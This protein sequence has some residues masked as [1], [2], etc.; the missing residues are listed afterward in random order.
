MKD[1]AGNAAPSGGFKT[2]GWY[3][4]YQYWNGSFAPQAG[5]IHPESN[6]QGAGSAAPT[7]SQ[8]DADYIQSQNIKASQIQSPI[9]MSL[10]SSTASS[11]YVTGLND[12]VNQARSAIENYLSTQQTTIDTKLAT[13]KEKEQ[14][15]LGEMKTL[16]TPFRQDIENTERNRLFINENFNANQNLVDELDQLL[17]EGNNLIRQQQEVT[18]LAAVR[19][20]RIQK[21]MDDVTA[22][23]GVIQAV[24][25]ARNGQIS[26]AENM[27][28]RTINAIAADRQDQISYYE[29]ILNL[30]RQDI[31]SLSEESQKIAEE[32]LNLKKGDLQRA[33]ATADYVKQLLIDP[34]TASLMA[35]GGVKLTDSIEQINQKVASAVYAREVKDMSNEMVM[36]GGMAVLDPNSVPKNELRVLTDSKG[37]KHYYQVK[38]KTGGIGGGTASERATA[39][40][41]GVISNQA[42]NFPDVVVNYANQLSLSEIY[43]AY[44]QSEMGQKWGGPSE[45]P[46]EIALLY[47]WAR[48][49]IT[50]AEYRAALEG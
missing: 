13:L 29:T 45:N 47:K 32:Q 9:S 1:P 16:T 21:A 3:S 27:I 34:A 23:A 25:N 30:N 5:M 31:I 48:G 20:P 37:V 33:Q 7:F 50:E 36:S 41:S 39:R 14:A 38:D 19:N 10:P 17:T 18:G 44:Q 26:V 28:D 43:E 8:K 24:I 11:E 42:M 4:G 46:N 40:I 22:R 6:Q 49:E 12:S 15:T 35:E 2:G